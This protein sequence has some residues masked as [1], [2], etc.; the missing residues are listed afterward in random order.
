MIFDQPVSAEAN[1]QFE[2]KRKSKI[3]YHI[4][5]LARISS[6]FNRQSLKIGMHFLPCVI[7]WMLFD[8]LISRLTADKLMSSI[9]IFGVF[10]FIFGW[11]L[12]YYIPN[13]L[14]HKF[15]VGDSLFMAGLKLQLYAIV[16]ALLTAVVCLLLIYLPLFLLYSMLVKVG[17]M[18]SF[19]AGAISRVLFSIFQTLVS[20]VIA[21]FSF[22]ATTKYF[23]FNEN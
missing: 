15:E 13:R 9:V 20:V 19:F 5:Q 10:C 8:F 3:G 16:P 11:W 17:L 4:I 7:A 1:A 12:K 23:Y 6:I 21:V 14:S 2:I 22:G 18:A